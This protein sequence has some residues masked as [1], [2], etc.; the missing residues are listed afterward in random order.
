MTDKLSNFSVQLP[1]AHLT[2]LSYVKMH[3][4]IKVTC[5]IMNDFESENLFVNFTNRQTLYRPI[6]MINK[7]IWRK[8][9]TDSCSATIII[10]NSV[11]TPKNCDNSVTSRQCVGSIDSMEQCLIC[12]W[13]LPSVCQ[14]SNLWDFAQCSKK[15]FSK[16]SKDALFVLG[17]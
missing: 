10:P 15:L 14:A 1:I 7:I 2:L 5:I 13:W 8:C 4:N 16:I 3:Q 11:A 12:F 9:Y 6:G 17:S